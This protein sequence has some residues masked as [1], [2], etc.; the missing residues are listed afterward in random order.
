MA[1]VKLR[2][3]RWAIILL[4]LLGHHPAFTVSQTIITIEGYFGVNEPVSVVAANPTATTLIGT[5]ILTITFEGHPTI[6]TQIGTSFGTQTGTI[7]NI[8]VI[9]PSTAASTELLPGLSATD[10]CVLTKSLKTGS[11][12]FESTAG[13]GDSHLD[14]VIR[15]VY[16]AQTWL[17]VLYRDGGPRKVVHCHYHDDRFYITNQFCTIN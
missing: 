5:N 8:F 17:N 16:V 7:I 1:L 11:C 2:I 3:T 13:F 14:Y 10:A 6:G 12:F 9:G 15:D 4:C